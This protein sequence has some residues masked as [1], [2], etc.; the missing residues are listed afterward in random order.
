MTEFQRRLFQN[1]AD[2]FV[3]NEKAADEK[4]RTH[5]PHGWLEGFE[6]GMV[7]SNKSAA[8]NLNSLIKLFS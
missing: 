2:H 3:A 1:L 5:D 6:R 8:A 4:S 7:A